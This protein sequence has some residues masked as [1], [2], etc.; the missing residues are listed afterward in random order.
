MLLHFIKVVLEKCLIFI[1]L[2]TTQ[3]IPEVNIDFKNGKF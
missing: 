2:F 1:F 3:F